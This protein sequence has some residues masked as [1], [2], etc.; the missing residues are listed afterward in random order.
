M[1]DLLSR[2]VTR[3]IGS[4]GQRSALGVVIVGETTRPCGPASHILEGGTSRL[5]SSLPLD[6]WTLE[7]MHGD[8]IPRLGF[9]LYSLPFRAGNHLLGRD[10]AFRCTHL[11]PWLPRA[12]LGGLPRGSQGLP[13]RRSDGF[14]G[15]AFDPIDRAL[16]RRSGWS[17]TSVG[18]LRVHQPPNPKPRISQRPQ[19]MVRISHLLCGDGIS[20]GDATK[21]RGGKGVTC[22]REDHGE[23][24][25]TTTTHTGRMTRCTH[26]QAYGHGWKERCKQG[27]WMPGNP[28]DGQ[29][30]E[31]GP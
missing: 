2:C 1:C 7:A 24:H 12:R 13:F 22:T 16:L 27:R 28:A 9:F 21:S 3:G 17:S 14:V 10:R 15:R 26:V 18:G 5:P 25:T 6:P 31:Q 23:R 8:R 29:T 19:R 11:A 20:R 30:R 4:F